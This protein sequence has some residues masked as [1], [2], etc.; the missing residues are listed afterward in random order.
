[1]LQQRCIIFTLALLLVSTVV[2]IAFFSFVRF[3]CGKFRLGTQES[4][5]F[6]S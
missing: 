1:M 4:G 6:D 2:S 5:H 3:V